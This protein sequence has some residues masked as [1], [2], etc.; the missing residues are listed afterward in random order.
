[1]AL[2]FLLIQLPTYCMFFFKTILCANSYVI[3]HCKFA[4]G[5]SYFMLYFFNFNLLHCCCCIRDIGTF[6]TLYDCIF[7]FFITHLINQIC[8]YILSV[9]AL[10][11]TFIKLLYVLTCNYTSQTSNENNFLVFPV[12]RYQ[13]VSLKQ[14]KYLSRF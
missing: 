9:K 8:C 11:K 14:N 12:E 7:S 2:V 5:R 6:F 13:C 4:A 10:L 1:M 3:A